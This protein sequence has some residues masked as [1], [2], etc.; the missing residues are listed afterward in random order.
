[1][2][3]VIVATIVP[4][5]E[6]RDAVL[7]AVATAAEQVHDEPGCELYA[8]HEAADRLVLVEKWASPEALA[9]HRDG[10]ALAALGSALRGKV[11]GAPDVVLLQAVPAGHAVKGQL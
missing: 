3:I 10:A 5:T 8:L 11:T 9:A 6:H 4:V 2:P 1:M 7:A